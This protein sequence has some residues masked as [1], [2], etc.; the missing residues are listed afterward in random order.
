MQLSSATGLIVEAPFVIKDEFAPTSFHV[1]ALPPGYTYEINMVGHESS[2]LL[3]LLSWLWIAR[4]AYVY[5]Y[6]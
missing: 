2:L 3:S 6:C 1:C 5:S 4:E